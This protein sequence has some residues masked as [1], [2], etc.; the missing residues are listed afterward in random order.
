[1]PCSLLWLCEFYY[2]YLHCA[3]E[4]FPANDTQYTWGGGAIFQ[5]SQIS[6]VLLHFCEGRESKV[7]GTNITYDDRELAFFSPLL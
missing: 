7:Q 1:M 3:L 4:V 2:L 6:R 5:K